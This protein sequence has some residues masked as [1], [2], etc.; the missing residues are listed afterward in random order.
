MNSFVEN[1][2]RLNEKYGK[3][4]SIEELIELSYNGELDKPNVLGEL[5]Q[6]AFVH[7]TN[8][9]PSDDKIKTAKEKGVIA[10]YKGY[11]IKNS[12][13]T[14][15]FTI[16]GTVTSHD[17]GN[18]D[19]RKYAVI[20]R[21]ND[22][23][24]N[25]G[26][27]IVTVRPEDTWIDGSANIKNAIILC[28]RNEYE[29][30]QQKN[31]NVFIIPCEAE[32]V[33][34]KEKGIDYPESLMQIMG[35]KTYEI[36]MWGY[37]DYS[38]QTKKFVK[39]IDSISE[40]KG[41]PYGTI[42]D[43]SLQAAEE[44]FQHEVQYAMK[45]LESE[46]QLD[47][48][49]LHKFCSLIQRC[50]EVSI[51]RVKKS[52]EMT[53]QYLIPLGICNLSVA[54]VANW[55]KVIE[56]D[57]YA[58]ER[59]KQNHQIDEY[60]GVNISSINSKD[61]LQANMERIGLIAKK[62][63]EKE[64]E[65]GKEEDKESQDI[66]GYAIEHLLTDYANLTQ[67]Y[68]NR[69]DMKFF[70]PK[71]YA[72][73]LKEEFKEI[74]IKVDEI[75]NILESNINELASNIKSRIINEIEVQA[76]I[77]EQGYTEEQGK[78]LALRDLDRIRITEEIMKSQAIESIKRGEYSQAD[79]TYGPLNNEIF[80]RAFDINE[81]AIEN[82][83]AN[84]TTSEAREELDAKL[85][86][87]GIINADFSQRENVRDFKDIMAKRFEELI[88]EAEK[89]ASEQQF[90]ENVR[91]QKSPSQEEGTISKLIDS[92]NSEGV[93]TSDIRNAREDIAKLVLPQD[94]DKESQ[95][96]PI[97]Q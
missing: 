68:V 91:T 75:D 20:I 94:K 81:E 2:K 16:N 77:E 17:R 30:V 89:E 10:N 56:F 67:C 34:D 83:I 40:L 93:G 95:Q 6:L 82:L 13:D 8:Y 70:D 38:P 76:L 69:V 15:H 36:G 49:F 11:D 72:K 9:L 53:N 43:E 79:K 59:I 85:R 71:E 51:D 48:T 14:T 42:H 84:S 87:M 29:S 22:F 65:K 3:I 80:Y 74:G 24:N 52:I 21:G 25:N 26:K 47:N 73:I 61:M 4:L 7:I 58:M 90:S 78:D 31:P 18:W 50:Q 86:E 19:K 45:K 55:G 32:N 46:K 44:R 23:V 97:S 64:K 39:K 92:Y 33:V 12:R 1:V 63:K 66:L 60:L 54:S 35:L 96:E 37:F 5:N 62:M 28:P 88:T 41:K 57:E 27:N